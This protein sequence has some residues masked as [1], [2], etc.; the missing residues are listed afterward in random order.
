L[1]IAPGKYEMN[2]RFDGGT[3]MVPPGLLGMKDEFGGSVGLL[4]V[5]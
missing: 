5:E 2:L 4:I 3:W 1:P